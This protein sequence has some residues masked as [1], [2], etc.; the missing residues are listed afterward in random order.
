[1]HGLRWHQRCSKSSLLD[2]LGGSTKIYRILEPNMNFNLRTKA[3]RE[4]DLTRKLALPFEPSARF[5]V[6]RVE[7]SAEARGISSSTEQRQMAAPNGWS[8]V[9]TQLNFTA[10]KYFY[11]K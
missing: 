1:M 6:Y 10:P 9:E 4:Q 8:K 2:I 5:R 7:Q 11:P 3:E